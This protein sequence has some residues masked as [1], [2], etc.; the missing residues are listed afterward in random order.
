[1]SQ[2]NG[3]KNLKF[4]LVLYIAAN[5][6]YGAAFLLFPGMLRD[7]SGSPDPIGLSWIRWAGGPLIALGIGAVKV[8]RNPS[9]QGTFIMTAIISELL[10]GLGLLHSKMFD[11]S[12]S[13]AW[14]HITPSVLSL[15]LFA[16]LVW[17]RQGARNV[18]E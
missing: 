3:I 5:L 18:L 10:T 1:M 4:V 7:I 14:F 13:Y 6:G 9:G 2:N 16:L 15:V 8:F 12:T 17:A 11:H